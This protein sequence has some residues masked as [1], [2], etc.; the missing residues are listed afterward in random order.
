MYTR[1]IIRKSIAFMEDRL[2]EALTLEQIAGHAG[3]SPHHFHRLFRREVGTNVA[4]Y[5]RRRRLGLASRML[6]YSEQSII[7]ISLHCHFESQEAFTRAFKRMYGMPPGRFRKMFSPHIQEP[8][9]EITMRQETKVKGWILSGSHPHQYEIGIDRGIVHQG[10]ASGY[11]KALT[12][13]GPGAFATLMQ[14]FKANHYVG[15]R[16]RFSGFVRT[17]GVKEY[18]GLW[19]RVDNSAEDVLQFDNMNDRKIVG[20]TNWNHY[21][22]VLDVPSNAATVSIGVLLM[23]PGQAWVDSFRFEE[24]DASVPTTNQELHYELLDEPFNL[25]FDE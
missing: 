10:H 20:D 14:Q 16:M 6:L 7:D 15:K 18:C 23:G 24:V 5:L 9:G 1:D 21:A 12:P 19:M 13:E 3:F 8:K 17:A 22:I 11:I 25:N 2:Q 4:D